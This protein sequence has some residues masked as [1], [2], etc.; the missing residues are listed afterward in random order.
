M[1]IS[2]ALPGIQAPR[3][4]EVTPPGQS[5]RSVRAEPDAGGVP[6]PWSRRYGDAG[7]TASAAAASRS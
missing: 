4:P 2:F 1:S 6:G 3:W 5:R 7:V